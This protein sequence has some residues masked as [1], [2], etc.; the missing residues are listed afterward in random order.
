[1]FKKAGY[2][3]KDSS[4]FQILNLGMMLRAFYAVQE[5]SYERGSDYRAFLKKGRNKIKKIKFKQSLIGKG[6]TF[7]IEEEF[8]TYSKGLLNAYFWDFYEAL[9][10]ALLR[11]IDAPRDYSMIVNACKDTIEQEAKVMSERLTTYLR[12]VVCRKNEEADEFKYQQM[13]RE[14]FEMKNIQKLIAKHVLGI[15]L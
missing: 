8:D 10:Y 11:L 13:V 6:K 14:P 12:R 7:Y 9:T 5:A 4:I 2:E 1:M 15:K 3:R